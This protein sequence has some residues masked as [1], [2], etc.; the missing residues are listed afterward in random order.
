MGDGKMAGK[1]ADPAEPP[2]EGTGEEREK[3]REREREREARHC[4]KYCVCIVSAN[5]KKILSSVAHS[6]VSAADNSGRYPSRYVYRS[7]T[8]LEWN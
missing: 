3:K 1:F 8:E 4:R 6:C 7:R 2:R 5:L